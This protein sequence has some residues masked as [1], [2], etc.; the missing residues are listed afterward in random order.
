M[1][2]TFKAGDGLITI[3]CTGRPIR[4]GDVVIFKSPQDKAQ[5]VHRVIKITPRGIKTRGD[6]NRLEDPWL[7]QPQDILGR[8]VEIQRGSRRLKTWNGLA[9]HQYAELQRTRRRLLDR[10]AALWPRWLPRRLPIIRARHLKIAIFKKPGGDENV[11][12]LGRR[13]I[14]RRRDAS[15]PWMIRSPYRFFISTATLAGIDRH[16]RTPKDKK[17]ATCHRQK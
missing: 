17:N 16:D 13:A 3:P 7:L 4:I 1:H 2:P 14:G 5:I 8:V 6:N 10:L 11:L 15:T 9:G 12:L